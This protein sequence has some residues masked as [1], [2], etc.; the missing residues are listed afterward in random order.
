L[1]FLVS[2]G[3]QKKLRRSGGYFCVADLD[4]DNGQF[5]GDNTGVFHF[6]FDRAAMRKLFVQAGFDDVRDLSAAEV[7]KPSVNG[8]MKRFA[9]F[10]M[11]GRKRLAGSG[12]L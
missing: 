11:A 4:V 3:G 6:G 12:G 8:E 9:I 10:L 7:V 1:V 5:H 2:G